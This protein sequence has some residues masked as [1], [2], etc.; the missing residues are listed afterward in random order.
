MPI[1]TTNTGGIPENVGDAGIVVP[2]GDVDAITKAVKRFIDE[3][4]LRAM[5]SKKARERALK[6]HDITVGAKKLDLLY[7]HLL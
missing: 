1:V 5:Y 7:Q 3:P 2:P 6:V 4:K